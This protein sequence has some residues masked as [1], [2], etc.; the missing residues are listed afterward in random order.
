[1]ADAPRARVTSYPAKKAGLAL[2]AL[3]ALGFVV[4]SLAMLYAAGLRHPDPGVVDPRDVVRLVAWAGLLFFG[5]SLAVFVQMLRSPLP[6][7]EVDEEGFT[8]R[9]S[10]IAAGRVS[11][12]EVVDVRPIA[13]AGGEW[14]AVTLVDPEAHLAR[15]QLF[16]R[17][18][19]R[20]NLLA[21]EPPV[22]IRTTTIGEETGAVAARMLEALERWRAV[23]R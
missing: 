2:L 8:D 19:V 1:M 11:W 15:L 12:A 13:R 16:R 23:Q 6:A 22:L 7:L 21:G 9:T 5:F 3:L 20:M 4:A 14:V 18:L 10:G 17:G